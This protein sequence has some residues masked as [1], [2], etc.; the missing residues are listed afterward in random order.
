MLQ[1]ASVRFVSRRSAGPGESCSAVFASQQSCTE[2]T[3]GSP[4]DIQGPKGRPFSFQGTMVTLGRYALDGCMYAAHTQAETVQRPNGSLLVSYALSLL[5]FILALDRA[6]R[7]LRFQIRPP[8]PP[9]GTLSTLGSRGSQ[10]RRPMVTPE[11]QKSCPSLSLV[12]PS[13]AGRDWRHGV[14]LV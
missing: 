14:E 2:H 9:P 8:I 10:I 4:R 5:R 3:C 1:N 12:N 7:L 6:E 13:S 11:S